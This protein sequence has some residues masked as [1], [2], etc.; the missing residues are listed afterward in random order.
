[1][2]T[3]A[4][5]L[6]EHTD[7]PLT[8]ADLELVT[9]ARDVGDAVVVTFT[10]PVAAALEQLAAHGAARVVHVSG[11]STLTAVAAAAVQQAVEQAFDAAP[12][13]LL[14]KAT[15]AN[16]E[17]LARAAH[18]LGAGLV[19]DAARVAVEDAGVVGAKRVFAGTWDVECVVPEGTALLTVRPNAV[20]ATPVAV[21][22]EV[23][24]TS[25]TLDAARADARGVELVSR[26]VHPTEGTGPALGEA[27]VV[28]AGGRGTGGDFAPVHELAEVLGGAVGSTRDCVDEGWIE[29]DTQVGQTGV[30]VTPRLYVGAGI[31]GAPHHRGGMQASEVIV[32]VNADP[33]CPLFEISDLAVVGDLA[34]VLP[35][36][37]AL[38]RERAGDPSVAGTAP[39]AS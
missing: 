8:A 6:L 36:A 35:R 27:A 31:S 7:A 9:I 14:A 28:V 5:V 33:E 18:L 34:L 17:I 20:R 22:T 19:I 37:A 38:L 16:K 1:M 25:L 30:T 24:V 39:D 3:T 2:T 4:A 11:T 29:H 23:E 21:P 10:P 13:L 15:F 12:R 32:A 26:T